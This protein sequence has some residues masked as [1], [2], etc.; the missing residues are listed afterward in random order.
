MLALD[1]D[2]FFIALGAIVLMIPIAAILKH[3][4]RKTA[5]IFQKKQ[6][7]DVLPAIMDELTQLRQEVQS[8][9]TDM[10]TVAMG[11]GEIK[12]NTLPMKGNDASVESRVREEAQ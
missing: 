12:T 10:N 7:D 9:R 11:I 4:Q 5:E 1:E 6:G 3:H 2:I 8:M